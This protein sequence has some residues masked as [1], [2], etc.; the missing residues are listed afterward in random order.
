M[1][2]GDARSLVCHPGTTTHCHLTDAQREA[3]GVRPGTLRL[4]VGLEDLE[5]LW[6]DLERALATAGTA[7]GRVTAR[8]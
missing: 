8:A 3:C 5:D 6:A 2:I 7:A 4:S 1:N